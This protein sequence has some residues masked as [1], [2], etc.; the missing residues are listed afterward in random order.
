[1]NMLNGLDKTYHDEKVGNGRILDSLYQNSFQDDESMKI[2]HASHRIASGAD[3]SLGVNI[4][5]RNKLMMASSTIEQKYGGNGLDDMDN[6]LQH[7]DHLV[8]VQQQEQ[9]FQGM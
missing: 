5:L 7:S 3:S 6:K 8:G 9:P 4:M 1:M 2:D